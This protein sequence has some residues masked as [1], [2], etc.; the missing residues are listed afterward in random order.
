MWVMCSMWL[1]TND[2]LGVAVAPR[3]QVGVIRIEFKIVDW[4]QIMTD[5]L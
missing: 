4:V 2:Q 5:F 1:E 3:T